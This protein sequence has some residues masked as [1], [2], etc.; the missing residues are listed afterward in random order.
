MI[1][2]FAINEYGVD[3][4]V[5]DIHGHFDELMFELDSIKFNFS[6]D[7][8]FSVGDLVDR[9]YKHREVVELLDKEWFFPVRGN[10]DQFIIDQFEEERVLIYQYED[11]TPQE[12]HK[13]LEGEWFAGLDAEEQLWFY[14]KLKELPYL[15]EIETSQG[16]IGLCHAGI[17]PDI[18][19]W[20]ELKSALDDRN[21]RELILR[22]RKA[23]RSD[24]RIKNIDL[25]VHGHTCFFEPK[26][27][28]NS[29]FIDTF[30]KSGKLTLR[31]II[32]II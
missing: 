27:I 3:Y 20:D 32:E 22:T 15:I 8:L 4:V 12:I 21:I 9:G 23:A 5:G 26:K 13:N 6:Q 24:R 10:H 29:L 14:E 30:D 25:T 2:K 1:N 17:P 16:V 31:K 28:G 19:D 7:R 11:Y 18:Y